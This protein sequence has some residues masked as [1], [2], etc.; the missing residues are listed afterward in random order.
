MARTGNALNLESFRRLASGVFRLLPWAAKPASPDSLLFRG[1]GFRGIVPRT[2]VNREV[3]IFRAGGR[4]PD[5][6]ILAVFGAGKTKSV[7]L[8]DVF[9]DADADLRN[10]GK[11]LREESFA[12]SFFRDLRKHLG[13]PVVVAGIEYPNRINDNSGLQRA[14]QNLS[15]GRMARVIAAVGDSQK[16]LSRVPTIAELLFRRMIIAS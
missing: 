5:A 16:N 10:A 1:N 13:I 9:G 2:R 3:A 12:S 15:E 7:L 14:V 8:T 11:L 6:M 4:Q